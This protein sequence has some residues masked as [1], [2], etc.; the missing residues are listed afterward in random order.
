MQPELFDIQ[1]GFGGG[2]P[3]QRQPAGVEE[4]LDDMRHCGIGRT[5]VRIAPADL[6]VSLPRSLETLYAACADH[7]ELVPCPVV[8]PN[9]A[10]DLPDE[11][12]QIRT[13]V[14]RGAAAAVIRPA[15]DSWSLEPWCSGR[16]FATLEERRLPVLCLEEMV[17]LGEV[18][19]LA[20]RHP[21]LPF[22]VAHTNYRAQRLLLPL[23]ER[24]ANVFLSLGNNYVVHRG[25]EQLAAVIGADRLLFGTGWPD[26][27]P[28]AAVT[29]L[30]Y[31][32]I[33]AADRKKIGAGN[34][35]R[36]L[37]KVRR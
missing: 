2:R 6:D 10:R 37:R 19:R 25:I 12:A 11:K 7:R 27:E 5:A 30:L 14:E 15:L 34:L 20:E 28:F 23:L 32:G 3:G 9:A 24:F 31:A 22:I 26:A 35:E 4:L 8:V 17:P 29:Q 33:K 18:A 36:L 1:A 16:L 13:A 21:R